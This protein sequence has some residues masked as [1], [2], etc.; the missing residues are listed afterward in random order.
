M[1][2]TSYYMRQYLEITG[3]LIE[4]RRENRHINENPQKQPAYITLKYITNCYKHINVDHKEHN[5]G[6]RA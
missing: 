1:R 5:S 3:F 2:H 4:T 6:A